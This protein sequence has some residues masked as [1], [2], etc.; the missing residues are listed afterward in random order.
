VPSRKTS[1]KGGNTDRKPVRCTPDYILNAIKAVE[2]AGSNVCAVEIT[3]TG[4][5][6]I[7]TGPR[8]SAIAPRRTTDASLTSGDTQ[9]KKKE[10]E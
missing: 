4:S 3:T 2:T 9:P 6:K 10:A 1:P 7:N 8:S 5:I